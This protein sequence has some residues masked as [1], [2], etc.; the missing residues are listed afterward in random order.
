MLAYGGGLGKGKGEHEPGRDPCRTYAGQRLTW[1]KMSQMNVQ[2]DSLD[3]LP[4]CGT[5]AEN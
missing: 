5:E 4:E 3:I 1:C 2:P